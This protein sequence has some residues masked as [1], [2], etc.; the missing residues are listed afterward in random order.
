MRSITAVFTLGTIILA[1]FAAQAQVEQQAIRSADGL[2]AA[3]SRSGPFSSY[4]GYISDDADV[5]AADSRATTGWKP[6]EPA[7]AGFV[8][9]AQETDVDVG[10]ASCGENCDSRGCGCD[11]EACCGYAG[12]FCDPWV[13]FEYMHAWT[14]N[15]WLPPLVTTGVGSTPPFL[16][17]ALPGSTILFGD[18]YVG[19]GL[20]P[21]GRLSFG[22][23]LDPYKSVG[24]GG[25][26]FAVDTASTDFSAA[27]PG[28][29]GTFLGRPFFNTGGFLPLGEVA[30]PVAQSVFPG[31]FAG[32][33][34][35]SAENDVLGAEG[36]VRT[37]VYQF[38][39]RRVDF[40][41]GYHFTR[42]DDSFSINHRS[43]VPGSP[44]EFRDVFAV[45]N[46]FHGADI[47]L[48]SEITRGP[49]T[50]S[51]LG[52][53]GM[54][55]MRQTVTITGS[56]TVTIGGVQTTNP[57]GILA[58]PTNIGTYTHEEF[59][60]VPE[61]DLKLL[62]RITKRLEAS[63]GYS[64]IYWSGIALAGQQIR[65]QNGTNTPILNQAQMP[66]SPPFAAHGST[67]PVFPGVRD[68][69]FWLQGLTIG[70]TY[71]R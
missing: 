25:K 53:M 24:F 11:S 48:L 47:G 66:S 51:L 41:L 27:S 45:E 22:A 5:D 30:W 26:F 40:L 13:T 35:A 43:Q 15:R 49:F 31:Q 59:S 63:I 7:E 39:Q 8:N 3:N 70:I 9:Y 33:V 71:K 23:W 16:Q 42:V 34:R 2:P 18:K 12:L 55:K 60:I 10:D 21:S 20:Q 44:F 36:F 65:V 19:N 58:L 57:G 14:R 38:G 1:A 64:F 4:A 67:D 6:F 37:A 28:A 62:C 17:G 29:G 46:H 69:D 68:T 52:K 61:A 54:G 32:D 56:N 50:L